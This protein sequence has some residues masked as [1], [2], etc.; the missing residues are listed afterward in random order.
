MSNETSTRKNTRELLLYLIFGGLTTLVSWG[1][2]ILFANDR[3][4]GLGITLSKVLSWILAVLFAFFTNKIW[5]FESKSWKPAVFFREI[6]SFFAARGI[7][8]L[9]EIFGTPALV[10]AGLTQTLFGTKGMVA[11][12]T[13]SV[14]VVILNYIFSKLLVFTKK[15]KKPEE[16]AAPSGFASKEDQNGFSV[17]H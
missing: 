7:T 14:V 15:R 3:F 9:L 12:I 6:L 8:G 5:V 11:N 16:P 13:V 10:K 1:T 17:N 2:Y 4:M